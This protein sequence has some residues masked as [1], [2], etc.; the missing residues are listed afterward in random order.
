VRVK[1]A[2]GKAKLTE[3]GAGRLAITYRRR[4]QAHH[5]LDPEV[6]G[7]ALSRVPR[8]ESNVRNSIHFLEGHT[9]PDENVVERLT[10]SGFG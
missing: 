4:T 1:T 7:E 2:R 10:S 5:S 9:R 6:V 8:V 3:I